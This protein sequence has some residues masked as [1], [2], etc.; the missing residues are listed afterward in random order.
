L[1]VVKYYIELDF[2]ILLIVSQIIKKSLPLHLIL[3]AEHHCRE[4]NYPVG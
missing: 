2:Y 3:A 1:V 4:L